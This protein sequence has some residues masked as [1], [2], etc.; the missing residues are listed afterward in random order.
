MRE[1]IGLWGDI[2]FV[3]NAVDWRS[4]GETVEDIAFSRWFQ[5]L[6][7][8]V[9]LIWLLIVGTRPLPTLAAE[10]PSTTRTSGKPLIPRP[11]DNYVRSSGALWERNTYRSGRGGMD[12]PL[13]R[14]HARALE[15]QEGEPIRPSP[16]NI[17]GGVSR[18]EG[19]LVPPPFALPQKPIRREPK[20]EDRVGGFEGGALVCP[21]CERTYELTESFRLAGP[22]K[23][24]GEARKEALKDFQAKV[25][26][27]DLTERSVPDSERPP[28][29]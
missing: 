17:F 11:E 12:G 4:V 7:L 22:G 23:T 15:Y 18:N 14:W 3:T 29:R 10:R 8:V 28:P 5:L 13:C 16:G 27:T 20:D 19:G 26:Q 2:D 21:T 9:G 25:R 6:S 1:I 24:V